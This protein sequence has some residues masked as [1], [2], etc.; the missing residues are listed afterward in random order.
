MSDKNVLRDALLDENG[1]PNSGPED[2]TQRQIA[3]RVLKDHDRARKSQSLAVVAWIL[4]AVAFSINWGLN[5][6]RVIRPN[7]EY[8]EVSPGFIVPTQI[9]HNDS[10][11]F[12]AFTEF[13]FWLNGAVFLFAVLATISW[14]VRARNVDACADLLFRVQARGE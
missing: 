14:L 13:M 7:S 10:S 5:V 8:T 1:L 9:A 11:A 4:H 6:N 12:I 3:E 2:V